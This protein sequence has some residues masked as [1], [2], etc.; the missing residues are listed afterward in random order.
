MNEPDIVNL[1]QEIDSVLGFFVV[2]AK[3]R[4][5]KLH[6]HVNQVVTQLYAAATKLRCGSHLHSPTLQS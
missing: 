2:E 6:D 1:A 3:D 5:L 4:D